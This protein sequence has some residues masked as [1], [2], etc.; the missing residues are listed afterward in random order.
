MRFL[1]FGATGMAGHMIS[2]YLQERGHDVIGFSRRPA[3]F[4]KQS[5]EGDAFD[6]SAVE[7]SIE[8]AKPDVV[9]N[10]IGLLVA[11]CERYHDRAVYLDAYVPHMLAALSERCG[12]RVFQLS[13]DCVFKGDT[14]PYSDHSVPDADEFYGKVKALGELRDGHNLTLRQ[15]IV[16]PDLSGDG[17]GLLNWFMKQGGTV[18]GWRHAI[19]TG[20][21]TLELAKAIGA[22]AAEGTSG[23]VNM[24]P[25]GPGISKYR[26]LS[27]FNDCMRAG[28]VR[29]QPDDSFSCDKS[30]TRTTDACSF[31]PSP[32]EDQVRELAVWMR[33]HRALYPHYAGVLR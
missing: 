33:E 7:R 14:G 24:V 29:V 15:S 19:W 13:T 28:E 2:L 4:L 32:Y 18:N 16:G 20:L 30:L 5:V 11:D 10:G 31:V 12:A 3:S 27:L 22:C 26:L 17:I 1:V 23:L 6:R 21:T 9:V 25:D 8:Q